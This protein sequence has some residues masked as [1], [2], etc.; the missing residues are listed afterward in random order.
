MLDAK[1]IRS[2]TLF[3]HFG[4]AQGPHRPTEPYCVQYSSLVIRRFSIVASAFRDT[5]TTSTFSN[6]DIV[7]YPAHRPIP[8]QLWQQCP[9]RKWLVASLWM[10]RILTGGRKTAT[11]S[12]KAGD[13]PVRNPAPPPPPL[14]AFAIKFFFGALYSQSGLTR[15]CFP[16]AAPEGLAVSCSMICSGCGCNY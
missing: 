7:R 15:Y 9:K 14:C 16:A 1:T 4:D 12:P 6:L 2:C 11:G 3:G 8:G 5:L 10:S 13:R